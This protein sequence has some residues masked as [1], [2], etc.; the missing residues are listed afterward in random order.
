MAF[1]LASDRKN[2]IRQIQQILRDLS[3]HNTRTALIAVDGSYDSAT[4]RAL[5]SFQLEH[6]LPPNGT[7]DYR[8][9]LSLHAAH[10]L[11]HPWLDPSVYSKIFPDIEEYVPAEGKEDD[12]IRILQTMLRE[13]SRIYDT[14]ETVE[15]NG[16]YDENTKNAVRDFQN[17]SL[18]PADG[19][20]TV[21]TRRRI[22]EE[23]SRL[24]EDSE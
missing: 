12:F 13:L 5:R 9:W 16:V 3:Y 19:K 1:F 8:T 20:L 7:V 4:E 21:N 14:A 22:A 24:T 17:R 6:G 2:V 10:K 15:I 18:L 11:I 23:Y